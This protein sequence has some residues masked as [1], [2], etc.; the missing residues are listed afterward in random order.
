MIESLEP[1][2]LLHADFFAAVN[3]QPVKAPRH[4]NMLIDYGSVYDVRRGGFTYGWTSP[5]EGNAGY[6]PV[7]NSKRNN[8]YITMPKGVSWEMAVPNG[9][10]KVYVV[11]GDPA[12]VNQRIGI[13]AEGTNI[14]AGI[15]RKARPFVEGGATVKVSDGK[16]TFSGAGASTTDKMNYLA[17]E[18]VHTDPKTIS[19][20]SQSNADE[21]GAVPGQMRIER[22]GDLS[23]SITVPLNVSGTATNEIDYGRMGDQV[24]FGVGVASITLPIAP[25][26]DNLVE[27]TET[28]IVSLGPV[29]G[30]ERADASATVTIADAAP[31]PD[32]EPELPQ[33]L[34]W[35][36][37]AARPLAASEIMSAEIDGDLYTFGGFVDN[38]F[39]PTRAAYKFDGQTRT[40]SALPN[41]PVG[42]THA[43]VTTDGSRVYFAGGYPGTGTNG[44]Q[45]FSS[46]T[47]FSF[48]PATNSY[49]NLPDLPVARASGA[50]AIAVG[51]LYFISGSD[52][53]RNDVN[54]VYALDLAN[55]SAGW[56]TRAALPGARNHA[57]AVTHNGR[58][59]LMGGQT[60]ND[61]G[62]TARSNLYRY[63]PTADAWVTLPSMGTP[64]SHIS[65]ATFVRGNTIVI[66]AGQSAYETALSSV[67]VYD[68][69]TRTW[70]SRSA[71][72]AARFSGAAGLLSDN[73]LVYTGGYNGGFKNQT[74]YGK[75]S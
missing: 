64:R 67:A 41:L 29:A 65:D 25:V 27:G 44:A 58:I 75:F 20:V 42:L 46:K 4:S 32:P 74:Y 13:F 62:L 73:T 40:W 49:T 23:D 51:K 28:V 8:T 2:Q 45:V 34:S 16:I 70:S 9:D 24:V 36:T 26:V 54:T 14:I 52:S 10:Y 39:K 22:T 11:A 60:G 15:T 55:T 72:P 50:L 56:V 66:I 47:V 17:I 33:N 53:S 68:L 19:I 37:G 59:Y 30:Y 38:T 57:A 3:F 21:N 6:S 18:A 63:D 48:N 5:Q 61:A 12:L 35:T 69:T 43:G 31:A 7:T 71:L 1:R